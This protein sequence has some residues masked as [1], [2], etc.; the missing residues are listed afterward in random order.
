MEITKKIEKSKNYV[1]DVEITLKSGVTLRYLIDVVHYPN[2]IPYISGRY[3]HHRM[4]L[5][6]SEKKQVNKLLEDEFCKM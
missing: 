5:T 1:Y 3:A 2:Q 6:T 4:E